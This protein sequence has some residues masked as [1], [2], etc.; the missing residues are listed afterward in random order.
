M[1]EVVQQSIAKLTSEVQ[2]LSY[3]DD[4]ILI[5]LTDDISIV[6][7]Q[8]PALQPTGLEPQPIL[9]T[10]CEAPGVSS[11]QGEALGNKTI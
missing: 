1:T 9:L 2:A 6:L 8:L 10:T 11:L 5:G 4:T 7:P 3:V